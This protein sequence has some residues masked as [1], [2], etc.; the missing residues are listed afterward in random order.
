MILIDPRGRQQTDYL[1][2][3]EC[4]HILRVF[5]EPTEQRFQLSSTTQGET[6]A[7]QLVASHLG[8]GSAG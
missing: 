5:S 4:L 8:S 3:W 2:A 1:V 7:R 6:Q